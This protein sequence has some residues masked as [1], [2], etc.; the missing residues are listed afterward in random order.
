MFSVDFS[1]QKLRIGKE[2]NPLVLRRTHGAQL[3][4]EATR[5]TRGV[6]AAMPK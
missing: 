3:L 5:I 4:S 2:T 1:K 6:Q